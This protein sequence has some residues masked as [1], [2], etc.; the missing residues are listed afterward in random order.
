MREHDAAPA[1]A[2]DGSEQLAGALVREMAVTTADA[3]LGRPRT[4]VVGLEK[5]GTVVGLYHHS[6]AV[7]E[8]LANVLWHMAEVG[9]PGKGAAG[10]EEVAVESGAETETDGI[11]CVVRYGEGI[12]FQIA[13]AESGAGLEEFPRQRVLHAILHGAG[14]GGVREERD[15]FALIGVPWVEPEERT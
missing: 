9:E 3:L 4:A 11:V 14:G 13:E 12:D 15:L 5:R 2:G 6:V 1:R 7:A 10:G 8:A